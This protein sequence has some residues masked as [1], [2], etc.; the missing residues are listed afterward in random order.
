MAQQCFPI[1]NAAMLTVKRKKNVVRLFNIIRLKTY[2]LLKLKLQSQI[3]DYV[4]FDRI[5]AAVFFLSKSESFYFELLPF[6]RARG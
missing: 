2:Q 5:N 1:K 4:F 6:R 3:I